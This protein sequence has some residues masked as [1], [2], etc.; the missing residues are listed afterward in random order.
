MQVADLHDG[1][2]EHRHFWQT[3]R[4]IWQRSGWR[5]FYVGLSIGYIQVVPMV[6]ISFAVYEQTKWF[7]GID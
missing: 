1:R 4:D 7:F 6:G 2:L 3:A 5:G